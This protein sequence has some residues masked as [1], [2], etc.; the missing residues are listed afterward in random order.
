MIFLSQFSNLHSVNFRLF[1]SL[2]KS[3]RV[4]K[5][6]YALFLKRKARLSSEQQEIIQSLAVALQSALDQKNRSEAE[7]LTAILMQE[8]RILAAKTYFEKS[9]D[10]IV[11]VGVALLFALVV[12][13][14]WFEPYV[15]PSGSM[16]PTLK[17]SDLLVV[18]KVPH[19]INVPM[20]PSH[21]Y[22]DEQL[23]QRG[24]IVTFTTENMD[25]D[26]D[27]FYFGLIPAK[28]QLVKRLIGKPGDSLYFYG[29][30]IYGVDREGRPLL[31]LYDAPCFQSLEYIPF[32][33]FEGKVHVSRTACQ[34]HQMNQ[35]VAN[36]A[37]SSGGQF[38]VEGPEGVSEYSDLWGMG[39]F[40]MARLLTP[41]E[42]EM[43][44]PSLLGKE[45]AVLYLELMHHPSL[46]DIRVI[47]DEYG[48]TRPSL[49]SEIS[50][51][52]LSQEEVDRLA[53]HLTTCRFEVHQG[54]VTR[55]GDKHTSHSVKL[56]DVPDGTYEIQQGIASQV[57][58]QGVLRELPLDHPLY[59]RTKER[60]QLLYNLGIEWDRSYEPTSLQAP[61]P[62]RYAYFREGDLYL[63][64][65]PFLDSH[66]PRLQ[67]FVAREEASKRFAPAYL[68][69]V[70]TGAPLT[71]EGQFDQ[72]K[73]RR[74]GL[75]VPDHSYLVLGDNHAMSGDSRQFGFVPEENL[76]GKVSFIFWPLGARWGAL[77]QPTSLWMTV[78]HLVVFV[79]AGGALLAYQ[80]R[81]RAIRRSLRP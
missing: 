19:G 48:R 66:S 26:A 59:P 44:H 79:I 12:R 1:Y 76:R 75:R 35:P 52:A 5:R 77:P 9:K 51:L 11:S 73:I 55:L 53:Q 42:A 21:F 41:R 78:P 40:A 74:F 80:L 49:S 7:R 58:I 20:T 10:L 30:K 14:M 39:H 3:R 4:L 31:E 38:R 60:V 25:L 81:Q 36:I 47:R 29:G 69:F 62:S 6:V 24:T 46:G 71:K 57:Y 28:K 43:L 72:E 65:A 18:S 70:D 22:F 16:R 54:M 63:L 33:R 32:I 17:E 37:F 13:Q 34:F 15:I 2:R 61:F 23:L 8:A 45:P 67:A 50:L 64:G 27:T 68:P 56:A